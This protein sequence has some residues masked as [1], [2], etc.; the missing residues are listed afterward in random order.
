MDLF[1]DVGW[2]LTSKK[3]AVVYKIVAT[4]DGDNMKIVQVLVECQHQA[5]CYDR[6]P[7]AMAGGLLPPS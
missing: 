1:L 7:A 2:H 5:A 4:H 6:R 3:N